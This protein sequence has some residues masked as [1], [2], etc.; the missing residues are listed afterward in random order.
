[1]LRLPPVWHRSPRNVFQPSTGRSD[2]QRKKRRKTTRDYKRRR[3]GGGRRRVKDTKWINFEPRLRH[4]LEKKWRPYL[5]KSGLTKP[6]LLAQIFVKKF[7]LKFVLYYSNVFLNL[8]NKRKRLPITLIFIYDPNG[9]IL[10]GIKSMWGII[11]DN[12]W[13]CVIKRK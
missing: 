9:S 2:Q 8:S 1:M 10:G 13:H 6:S 5:A 7:A 12:K 3:R 4:K 11:K